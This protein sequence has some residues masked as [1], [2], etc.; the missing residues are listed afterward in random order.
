[1]EVPDGASPPPEM[2][3]FFQEHYR[4][5]VRTVRYV[6]ADEHEATEAVGEALVH[7]V[8]SWNQVRNP[9]AWTA[10]VAIRAFLAE[11]KRGPERLRTRM[12]Q[13]PQDIPLMRTAADHEIYDGNA[14]VTWLLRQLPPEQAK[15]MVLVAEGM[16][17][18]EIATALGRSVQSIRQSIYVSRKRLKQ[19]VDGEEEAAR[20][21]D[22]GSTH[23]RQVQQYGR[24]A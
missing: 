18:E 12:A 9:L 10:K 23:E 13:R 15:V 2:A 6:G 24:W 4:D 22:T 3:R 16:K 14:W 11:K 7:L 5:L 21:P 17:N 20:L 8:G 1:M 19:I